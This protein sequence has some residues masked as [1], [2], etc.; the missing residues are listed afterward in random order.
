M[1][2]SPLSIMKKKYTFEFIQEQNI[3]TEEI[4]AA[5]HLICWVEEENARIIN[6]ESDASVV[7][8]KRDKKGN[9][10]YAQSL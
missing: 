4:K 8:V 7:V 5:D 10:L 3:E 2:F 6:E 1:K 9:I